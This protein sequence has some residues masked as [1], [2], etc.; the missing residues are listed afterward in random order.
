LRA[1]AL[2]G[3]ALV[4]CGG[5]SFDD[6]FAQP[7]ALDA[8]VFFDVRS[9]DHAAPDRGPSPAVDARPGADV[10]STVDV[11][12]RDTSTPVEDAAWEAHPMDEARS[13]AVADAPDAPDPAGPL[14]RQRWEVPCAQTLQNDQRLCS[15][16]PTGTFDCQSDYRPVDRVVAFGGTPGTHYAVTLRLRGVVE[17][18]SYNGGTEAGAHFQ[19]GGTPN[20][21]PVNVF[22]FSV[23]SPA[24]T[25]YLNADHSGS[26]GVVV[27]VD[28]TVTVPIDGGA[29]VELFV[30]DPDCA[31]L[32]NCVYQSTPVCTPYVI[33]GIPPAPNA[34][35]GQFAQADVVVV[36]PSP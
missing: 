11:S 7:T 28:D 36:T 20:D 12:S 19:V 21:G 32:R 34:F 13:D 25:Y 17:L 14:A 1:L 33:L 23:S 27:V 30:K 4:G 3:P 18:K 22:G 29:K 5:N 24:Q 6:L 2:S 26:G 15:S 31:E 16:L 10:Q 8:G 9:S 35:V